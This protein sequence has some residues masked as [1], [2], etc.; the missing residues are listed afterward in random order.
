MRQWI[1]PAPILAV[2]MLACNAG[3]TPAPTATAQVVVITATGAAATARPPARATPTAPPTSAPSAEAPTFESTI[4]FAPAADTA[5]ATRSFPAATKQVFALWKYR[6]MRQGLTVRR[7]WYLNGELWLKREETWDFN[8]YG[9][10]GLVKN[11]SIYDLD[12]GLPSGHYELKLYIDGQ[13]QFE[14][15]DPALRSFDIAAP[16]GGV[17]A[18]VEMPS[19]DGA[20]LLDLTAKFAQKVGMLPL[21]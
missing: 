9:A 21:L 15:A 3:G 10:S 17:P 20:Y 1:M 7:E 16:A 4:L 11:I 8:Q 13:S 18:S 19:P 14:G 12:K 2:V 5:L 6:S